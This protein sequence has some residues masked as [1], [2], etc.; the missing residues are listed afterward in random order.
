MRLRRMWR[1]IV[2]YCQLH[3]TYHRQMLFHTDGTHLFVYFSVD[4]FKRAQSNKISS[5]ENTLNSVRH[6][7]CPCPMQ[8]KP[9]LETLLLA[10]GLLACV[11]LNIFD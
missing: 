7:G 2:C 3:H 6:V 10:L 11:A 9:K 5:N 1:G 8:Y 4:V